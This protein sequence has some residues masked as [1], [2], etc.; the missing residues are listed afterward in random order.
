MEQKKL[1]ITLDQLKELRSS[2]DAE[3]KIDIYAQVLTQE[4]KEKSAGSVIMSG[5]GKGFNAAFD[6]IEELT[7]PEKPGKGSGKRP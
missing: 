2:K 3:R 4:Y 5:V 6:K 7:R 1:F